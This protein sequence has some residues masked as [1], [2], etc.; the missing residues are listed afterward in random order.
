MNTYLKYQPPAIQFLS[1]LAIAVGCFFLN[2]LISEYFFPDISAVLLNKNATIS[3]E[4]ITRFKIAQLTSAIVSFLVP[5]LL[6]GYFSSPKALPYIGLQPFL[7]PVVMLSTII[8]LFTIQPFI[9]YLGFANS[10]AHFGPMQKY[11][12]DMEDI[13]DRAM[14]VFLQ[15]HNVG[16]LIFNLFIMALLPAVSEELFFR[17]AFQKVFLRLTNIPWLAI[18]I[19]ASIFALLHGTLLKLVPIFT[20]GLLL[21]IVYHITRNIWYTITIHFINNGFALIAV[22]YGD[23]NDFLKKLTDDNMPVPIYQAII[24]LAIGLAVLYFIKKKSEKV[25]PQAFTNEDNDYL[26]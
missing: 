6:L 14:K 9:G 18:L 4:I 15:M 5:A 22:Y 11:V 19:S 10:H 8:L 25:L 7:S 12:N 3:S 21:G 17:G 16:D 2:Y 1:F 23:R 13:Y 24:S 26:A 20:L